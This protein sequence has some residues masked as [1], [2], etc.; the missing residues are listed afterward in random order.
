L[1]CVSN[2]LKKISTEE[3]VKLFTAN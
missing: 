1:Q 2:T 3:K